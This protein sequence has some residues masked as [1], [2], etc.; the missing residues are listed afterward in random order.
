M[1]ARQWGRSACALLMFGWFGC[2]PAHDTAGIAAVTGFDAARYMGKW[3]EIARLPH[4]FERDVSEPAAEYTLRE[5]GTVR[6]VNS[7]LRGGVP[8]QAAGVARFAGKPD[9]GELEV[10]FFR[11]FYGAYRI[12]HLEPD[13]SAAVVTS[14]SRD[15][16]WILGRE[17]SLPREKLAHYLDWLEQQ[18][19]EVKLLQYPWGLVSGG[20]QQADF[21]LPELRK[22]P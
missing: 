8:T 17:K 4:S 14:D 9:V 11:P 7:G 10:S 21:S 13:Y 1:T 6:V 15:Y 2:R 3:Y 22:R 18:G 20:G 5:D 16:L 12:I 19:F